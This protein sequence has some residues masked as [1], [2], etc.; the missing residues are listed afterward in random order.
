MMSSS[1]GLKAV[2]SPSQ[3]RM[4]DE[5]TK[6]LM[7][8]RTAPVSSQTFRYSDGWFLSIS[9]RAPRTSA[10]VLGSS[11]A[12]SQYSRNG[13]GTKIVTNVDRFIETLVYPFRSV[14]EATGKARGHPGQPSTCRAGSRGE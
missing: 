14:F 6:I 5:L 9:R 7:W 11:L 8:R 4:C 1:P 2:S 12:P 13:P 10:A 3:S